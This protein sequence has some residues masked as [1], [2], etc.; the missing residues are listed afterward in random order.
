MAAAGTYCRNCEFFLGRTPGNFCAHCGQA[1]ALHP[2]ATS[3]YLR[4]F[5]HEYLSPGG[6]LMRSL[7]LLLFRPGELTRRYLIGKR[8]SHIAPFRLYVATSLVFFLVVKVFGSDNLF[9]TDVNPA[10][11]EV[12][13]ASDQADAKQ[14][15]GIKFRRAEPASSIRKDAG[16]PSMETPFVKT[17]Q[18]SLDSKPCN[19]IR[20]YMLEK[21]GDASLRLV[22]RQIRDRLISYAPNAMIV[23]LPFFALITW[24]LY[25]RRHMVYGEHLAY[26]LHVHAFSYLLLLAIALFW[27]AAANG[28]KVC[29][30]PQFLVRDTEK[31][32]SLHTAQPILTAGPIYVAMRL[33][34]PKESALKG[35]WKPPGVKKA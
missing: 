21:Y 26:A 16:E 31:M 13:S 30:M 23:M 3:G 18:C 15:G 20:A 33:Y 19:K 1:T 24:V 9:Q 4:H 2:P 32:H 17:I 27:A 22:G 28:P 10:P 25:W 34:W 5:A 14:P 6:R 11:P 7:G 8:N 12:A 29:A 35:T